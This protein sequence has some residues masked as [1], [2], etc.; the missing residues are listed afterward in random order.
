MHPDKLLQ[1]LQGMGP[2]AKTE[3]LASGHTYTV[4]L[5]DPT[6]EVKSLSQTLANSLNLV[7]DG[8]TIASAIQ[9]L[10]MHIE[11]HSV[12]IIHRLHGEY[13]IVFC[14]LTHSYALVRNGMF[15]YYVDADGITYIC[16]SYANDRNRN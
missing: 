15:I 13:G 10:D 16:W 7:K 3:H 4:L 5:T 9:Q 12:D 11:P 14:P 2:L 6:Q 8:H 1:R